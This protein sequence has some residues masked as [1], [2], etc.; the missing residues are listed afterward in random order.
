MTRAEREARR[1][2][3]M[4][5][6]LAGALRADR[7]TVLPRPEGEGER[8][9]VEHEVFTYI[10]LVREDLS[11]VASQ[12][13]DGFRCDDPA[14]AERIAKAFL[15]SPAWEVR[16]VLDYG[17]GFYFKGEMWEPVRTIVALYPELD[18]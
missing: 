13:R 5:E 9:R 8:P 6:V 14:D 12:D 10:R 3:R 15:S 7:L 4:V 16:A 2:L 11:P 18:D 1:L 17:D